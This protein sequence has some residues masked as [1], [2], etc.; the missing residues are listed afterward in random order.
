MKSNSK[1][2]IFLLFL[3]LYISITCG[4]QN[5]PADYPRA[6]EGTLDLSGW[7]FAK[8]GPVNLE[9]EWEFYWKQLWEPSDLELNPVISKGFITLPR[10]WN[11]YEIDGQPLKGEGYAT[12]RLKI[13]LPEH[14][15]AKAINLS[16]I[17]SSHKLW[18]NGRL[19]SV[20]GRVAAERNLSE[21]RYFPKIVPLALD[22]NSVELVIQVA[23]FAHRRG[24]IWQPIAI[25]NS[26]QIMEIRERKMVFDMFLMGS[27][28]IMGFYILACFICAEKIKGFFISEFF[29]Y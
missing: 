23:N 22:D 3:I 7:D 26:Q 20:Q 9:G 5:S 10:S 16:S 21:T 25:G 24:G 4:C 27:L 12:F 8:D 17:N 29:A 6:V 1:L 15:E 2:L 28:W 13:L 14:E 19:V 11:G 18:V